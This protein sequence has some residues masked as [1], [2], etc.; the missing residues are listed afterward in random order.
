MERVRRQGQLRRKATRARPLVP[1]TALC[2][3]NEQFSRSF[4]ELFLL[5]INL[6]YSEP[7]AADASQNAAIL[8]SR[9]AYWIN[10]GH[11]GAAQLYVC[12]TI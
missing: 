1:C 6:S 4:S 8:L 9:R 10:Q 5:E 12:S 11:L 7:T 2:P 3:R